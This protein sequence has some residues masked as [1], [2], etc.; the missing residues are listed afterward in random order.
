MPDFVFTAPAVRALDED[1]QRVDLL[2]VTMETAGARIARRL[3]ERRS[4]GSALILAGGGAN[5]GDALVAARHLLALG[6]RV[7]VLALETRHPL[8][9]RMRTRLEA[10]AAVRP[11]TPETLKAALP[12]ADVVLDGLLGTGFEPP[13]RA[14]IDDIVRALDAGGR[15]VVSIDVPSGLRSDVVE[16][17]VR[18]RADLTFA[19]AGFKPALLFGDVGEVEVLDLGVPSALLERYAVARVIDADVVRALLPRRSKGAHKGTAGRV[20]ILG[21]SPGYVGAPA[22]SALGALRAGSGLVSLYSRAAIEQHPLEAM[23]HH[24][25][26]WADLPTEARPDALAVG[27]G[28]RDDGPEVARTVLAWHVKTVLDADAL[29]AE[30]AGAGHDAA[31]WTPHPGEAARLLGSNVGDV[32]RDPFGSARALRER[33]GGTVVLKGA[34]TLVATR[35]GMWA[36]PFGNPGM[37]TGGMGDVLSGVIAALLGQG[38]SGADAAVLGVALHALAGDAAAKRFGYGLVASDVAEQVAATWQNLTRSI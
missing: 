23:P 31:V 4:C 16:E 14:P 24:L 33:F 28:L 32:T 18:V 8:A 22:L 37:A 20:W 27:M 29:Q 9:R 25:E 6:W 38:L 10:F 36:C 26:R 1:L 34:P 7:D 13:L 5:G 17:D 30:L 3:H 15:F 21:G 2:E 19:L 12:S 35:D 11:L